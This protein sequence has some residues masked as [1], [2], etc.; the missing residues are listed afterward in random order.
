MLVSPSRLNTEKQLWGVYL[1]MISKHIT[2]VC[3][4]SV[5]SILINNNRPKWYKVKHHYSFIVQYTVVIGF[6]TYALSIIFTD[7]VI[8]ITL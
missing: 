5:L 6:S 7:Y 2:F 8:Q 3:I 1:N 4:Y